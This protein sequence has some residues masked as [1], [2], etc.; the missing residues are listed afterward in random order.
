MRSN[1]DELAEAMYLTSGF[2][3][4]SAAQAEG[5]FAG[6][7]THFQY[8]RFGNPTV[9]MLEGRL[10]ALEGAEACRATATSVPV[11]ASASVTAVKIATNTVV[12]LVR[13]M[14]RNTWL[15]IAFSA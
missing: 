5:T 9:S 15:K 8:S 11:P 12:G 2:V 14:L 10:A 6:T 3:Y 7:E 4:D 13:A 1:F